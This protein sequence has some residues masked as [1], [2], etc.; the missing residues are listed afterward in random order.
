MTVH[1]KSFF[2]D[3]DVETFSVKITFASENFAY[4]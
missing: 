1:T 3:H 2:Q 4:I